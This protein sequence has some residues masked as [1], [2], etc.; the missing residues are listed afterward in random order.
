MKQ[1][2]WIVFFGLVISG[3]S[4]AGIIGSTDTCDIIHVTAGGDDSDACIGLLDK[5]NPG[6]GP[7]DDEDFLNTAQSFDGGAVIWDA[8]GAF[9]HNDWM[10]LGKDEQ[11]TQTF[12]DATSGNPATWEVDLALNGTFLISVKQSNEIGFWY[13]EDL[14]NVTSGELFIND[15]F[16]SGFTD[17]GWSHVSIYSTSASVP[18]PTLLAL[19]SIGL[20][21]IGVAARR[22]SPH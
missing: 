1:I 11:T 17:D 2:V 20:L 12:I 19:L 18:E 9:G 22:R 4:S 3:N 5:S 16:G 14:V 15:I 6:P 7:N 13:F 10:F 21:G 8:D